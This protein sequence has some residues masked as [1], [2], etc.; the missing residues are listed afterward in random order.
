M[1]KNVTEVL[2]HTNISI[3]GEIDPI[4]PIRAWLM[5]FFFWYRF[6]NMTQQ[7]VSLTP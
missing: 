1:L 3:R 4:D 6:A 7:R 5:E 2:N